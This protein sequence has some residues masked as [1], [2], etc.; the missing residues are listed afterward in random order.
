[1]EYVTLNNGIKMPKLGFGVFQIPKEIREQCV[2]DAIKTGYR[3]ID[4]AQSYFNEEEVGNAISKCA[5]PREELFITTKVWIDNYGYEKTKQ[6][7]L[8]SMEKLKVDYVDL[9]LLHQPFS[10]YYGAYRALQ[11][12]YKE[13]KIRAIGVSNFSPDRLADIIAFNAIAPQVNQVE[14]NPFHQ[15]IEAQKNMIKRNVQMQA[16]APFG[17]GK[18]HMFQNPILKDIAD[19]HR[20][21]TAQ[22]ILRWLMQRNIVALAKSIHI[23]RMKENLEIFDFQISDEEMQ[24][25]TELDTKTSLFFDHQTPETVDRFVNLIEERK[26]RFS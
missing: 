4:T 24:Q 2:L 19:K 10:D 23:E 8:K 11:D 16:W 1:M 18:N 12:L 25:T 3:H 20:K 26:E 22:V 7:V 5:I 6:S 15:Q 17:E 21:T 13:K 14:A 9:I